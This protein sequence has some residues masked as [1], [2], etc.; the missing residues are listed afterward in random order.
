MAKER[1]LW[2]H[3]GHFLFTPKCACWR[4]KGV[5]SVSGEDSCPACMALTPEQKI[6]LSVPSYKQIKEKKKEKL[7]DPSSVAVIGPASSDDHV[8]SMYTP[9]C[10]HSLSTALYSSE[11]QFKKFNK[12]FASCFTRLESVLAKVSSQESQVDSL[13]FD[14]SSPCSGDFTGEFTRS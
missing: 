14:P 9:D 4:E 13:A 3:Y 12:L 8:G 1:F 10:S 5:G 2:P 6:Q 7:V 11:A